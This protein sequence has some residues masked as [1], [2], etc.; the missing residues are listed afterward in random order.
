VAG[1]IWGIGASLAFRASLPGAIALVLVS[2]PIAAFLAMNFTG[3]STF[4]CQTGAEMEVRRGTPPMIILLA[5]GSGLL[6][7][8]RFIGA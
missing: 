3:A 5:L 7:A 1:I 8:A 2:T 4:T 6:I